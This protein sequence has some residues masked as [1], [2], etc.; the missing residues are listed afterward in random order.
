MDFKSFFITIFLGMS[1]TQTDLHFLNMARQAG[2]SNSGTTS[3]TPSRNKHRGAIIAQGSERLSSG[4]STHLGGNLYKPDTDE[5]YVATVNAEMIALGN[6]T[7]KGS[8]PLSNTT[9]Y[10]SDSPNWYTFKMLVTLGIRR[11]VHYG[12]VTNERITHY[13]QELN[14]EIISVG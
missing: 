4:S 1:L 9:I 8:P 7:Q 3:L 11:I 5:R 10:I 6:L 13:A 12:P 2:V 14:I